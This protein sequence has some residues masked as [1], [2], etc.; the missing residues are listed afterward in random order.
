MKLFQALL[1]FLSFILSYGCNGMSQSH[2]SSS[3]PEQDKT[4]YSV[5]PVNPLP[6]KVIHGDFNRDGRE[7]M[8]VISKGYLLKIYINSGDSSFSDTFSLETY[9]NS[10]SAAVAD[11]NQD[12]NDDVMMLTETVL[13]PVFL[14][15]SFRVPA[16]DST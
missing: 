10:T 12:G 4:A 8:A 15:S 5:I 14:T 2:P 1:I 3:V 7:D 9:V 13:G 11:V 6:F 16:A